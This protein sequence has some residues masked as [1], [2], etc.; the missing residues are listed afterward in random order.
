MHSKG[1]SNRTVCTDAHCEVGPT[2]EMMDCLYCVYVVRMD[3]S[4][5][6]HDSGFVHGIS[7]AFVDN[8]IKL[9]I[10]EGML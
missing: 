8:N 6:W 10:Y 9:V 3:A 1:R 5:L 7:D 2:L 4:S